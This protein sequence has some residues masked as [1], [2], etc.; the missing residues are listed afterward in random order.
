[1]LHTAEGKTVVQI[2]YAYFYN[3]GGKDFKGHACD[4]TGGCDIQIRACV[5]PR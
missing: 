5:D 1:M 2:E 3:P 4:P